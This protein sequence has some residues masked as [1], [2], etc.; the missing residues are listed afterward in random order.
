MKLLL[1]D[2]GVELPHATQGERVVFDRQFAVLLKYVT[3]ACRA[4]CQPPS[5]SIRIN[6]ALPAEANPRTHG[7]AEW[8]DGV[9]TDD[10]AP[11]RKG[12]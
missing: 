4:R 5:S 1:R 7:E 11:L 9:M 8:S 12:E 10:C 6:S 3:A 2:F